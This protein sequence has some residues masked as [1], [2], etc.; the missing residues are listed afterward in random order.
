M[1]ESLGHQ[2]RAFLRRG[3]PS[4]ARASIVTARGPSVGL[5][6]ASTGWATSGA[7]G[8]GAKHQTKCSSPAFNDLVQA[9]AVVLVVIAEAAEGEERSLRGA[10]G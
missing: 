2:R 10:A 5:T 6:A 3:L 8:T 9:H 4:P 7:C 1:A